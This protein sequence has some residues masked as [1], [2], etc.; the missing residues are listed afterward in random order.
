MACGFKSH[1]SHHEGSSRIWLLLFC[2]SPVFSV[3]LAY[4]TQSDV[5]SPIRTLAQSRWA[6]E[7]PFEI[8]IWE[9][10]VFYF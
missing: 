10:S 2:F 5:S 1:L 3:F 8:N 4:A 9:I 6:A 7:L